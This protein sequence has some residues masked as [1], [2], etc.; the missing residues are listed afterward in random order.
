MKHRLCSSLL[1]SAKLCCWMS[2]FGNTCQ[3]QL[4]GVENNVEYCCWNAIYSWR[5]LQLDSAGALQHCHW[6]T[7]LCVDFHPC[8]T[9]CKIQLQIDPLLCHNGDFFLFP[10]ALLTRGDKN[11]VSETTSLKLS[12]CLFRI[13][14]RNEHNAWVLSHIEP[15]VTTSYSWNAYA[16][17]YHAIK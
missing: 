3:Q 1:C 8:F 9:C 17:L 10:A 7:P 2:S 16:L 6:A 14:M 5:L 4:T 13:N 15:D 11:K 12:K